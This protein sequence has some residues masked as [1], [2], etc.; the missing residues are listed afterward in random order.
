MTRLRTE[1][2]KQIP[3]ALK[4]YDQH[5][6][7]VTGRTLKGIACHAHDLPE[8]ECEDMVTSF[9]ICVVPM[10]CGQG[11]I[12]QFS[13]TVSGIISHLGFESC[14]AQQSDAAGIAEAFDNKSDI[15]LVADDDRFV[16][17]NVHT[18]TVSDNIKMTA[19]GFVAGLD[20]MA[21]GLEEKK[22]LVIGCGDVGSATAKVLAAM[23]AL[24]SV[25]DVT[26][27]LALTL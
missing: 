14:V 8:S 26:P 2:I 16:A 6:L 10:T 9:K 23:G 4:A 22:A 7:N 18:R 11:V 25:C 27:Q 17:I 1:D 13:E 20:L 19:K 24:V 21:S 15:I 3:Q 5:L 12:K